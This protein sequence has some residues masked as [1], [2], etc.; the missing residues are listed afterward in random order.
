M[1][2]AAEVAEPGRT[3]RVL[4][5]VAEAVNAAVVLDEEVLRL[6]VVAMLARG[7]VLLEDVPGVGKTLLARTLA[8]AIGGEFRRVQFTPD[9]LPAD[10]T[11]GNVFDPRSAEFSF[12]QGPIF[13]NIVLADEINRGTPRAQAS[14]LEAMGEGSVSVDGTTHRLPDPFLVIATQNP[15]EQYGTFPLPESEL[16]R[17]TMLLRVGRPDHDQ[18]A[19]ILRRHEHSEPRREQ[20]PVCDLATIRDAQQ[21]VLKVHVSPAIREYIVRIV[22]ATRDHPAIGLPASPRASVA[23]L[24]AA[25]AMAVYEDRA[26]V[27]PDDV[28]AVAPSVLGHRLSVSTAGGEEVVSELLQRVAVPLEA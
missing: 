3:G 4:A 5:R 16:D 25:Q 18:Q 7:H 15:I 27:L 23:L 13:A 9:L 1:R 12:R 10:V 17:F 19:E 21:D 8:Q 6:A 22:L 24:R 14:L 20:A 26:H 28:K 2:V 11:G